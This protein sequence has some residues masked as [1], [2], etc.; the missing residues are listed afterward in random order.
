MKREYLPIEALPTWAKLNGVTFHDVK[1]KRLQTEDG[2]DKGSAV[3]ATSKKTAKALMDGGEIV[4]D[5]LITVPRDLVLSLELVETWAK[6][7]RHLK[8]VLDAV[9]E[10]GRV[11][12]RVFPSCSLLSLKI[13]LPSLFL[14][15]HLRSNLACVVN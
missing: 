13:V 7:D 12:G 10:Y 8:E 15:K 2:V 3:V 6:S 4:P 14:L 1:I 11:S 9:G 5:I